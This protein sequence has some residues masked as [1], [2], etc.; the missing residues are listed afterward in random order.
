MIIGF[1]KVSGH[2][3]EPYLHEGNRVIAIGHLPYKKGDVVI[4]KK[5]SKLFV[6]RISKIFG[7]KVIV[8]GDNLR[9][10]FDGRYFGEIKKHDIIGKVV[11][12]FTWF[13]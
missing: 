5:D 10:S 12:K 6:K 9:D 13:T 1:L 2:S 11:F 4:A 7:D 8:L 3:M